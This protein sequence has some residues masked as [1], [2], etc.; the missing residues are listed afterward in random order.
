MG[1]RGEAT[2]EADGREVRILFTNRAL[3]EVEA[4]LGQSIIE[5]AKGLADGSCGITEAVH[6]LRAG[7]EAARRDAREGGRAISLVD[8]YPVLDDVG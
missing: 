4:Q 7:M 1:A 2:I 5:V 8:A 3:A 6:L